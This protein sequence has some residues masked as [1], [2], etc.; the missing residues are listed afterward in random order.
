[1]KT[2]NTESAVTSLCDVSQFLSIPSSW[3]LPIN[4][5]YSNCL[6]VCFTTRLQII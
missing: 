1:M 3:L 4:D 6:C 2:Q 5:I